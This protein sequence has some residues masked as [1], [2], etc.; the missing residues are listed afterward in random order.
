MKKLWN[1]PGSFPLE[2][3]LD[4]AQFVAAIALLS[5]GL[6][7]VLDIAEGG[8]ICPECSGVSDHT[9]EERSVLHHA[10]SDMEKAE[11]ILESISQG[12]EK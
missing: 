1:T 3:Q 12:G 2:S 8:T 6:E 10:R 11:K 7:R 5:V 9:S 4:I